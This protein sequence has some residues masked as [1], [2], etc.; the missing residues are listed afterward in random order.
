MP[1]RVFARVLKHLYRRT[2]T[3]KRT[4]LGFSNHNKNILW[5]TTSMHSDMSYNSPNSAQNDIELRQALREKDSELRRQGKI[6]RKLKKDR[7]L[8]NAELLE[9]QL[10]YEEK[11]TELKQCYEDLD[12]TTQVL[13]N[14]RRKKS[15]EKQDEKNEI[16]MYKD[17]IKELLNRNEKQDNIMKTLMTENRSLRKAGGIKLPQ[18]KNSQSRLTAPRMSIT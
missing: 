3:N 6:V 14:L 15:S 16:K 17:Y 13:K 4:R 2:A 5:L 7:T 12:K 1:F 9:W 18:L 8:L 11:V 10:K